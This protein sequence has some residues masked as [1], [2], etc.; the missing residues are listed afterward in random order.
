[1]ARAGNA[2]AQTQASPRISV[3]GTT[4]ANTW[5]AGG[6]LQH[7]RFRPLD[8]PRFGYAYTIP[9]VFAQDDLA[10]ARWLTLSASARIDRHS[11]RSAPSSA[12]DSPSLL[13]PAAQWTARVSGGGGHFAPSPFTEETGATGL[14]ILA[15]MQG[16]RPEDRIEHL[17]RRHV[18]KGAVRVD[19]DGVSLEHRGRAGVPEVG[20]WTICG[21]DRQRRNP[22]PHDRRGVHRALSHEEISTSS[23]RTCTCDRRRSARRGS[24]GA[25]SR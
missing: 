14:S 23:P 13:R 12:H 16:V 11:A 5:V 8:V 9:G 21:T 24:A 2:S 4:G 7:E 18:E 10:L 1:L 20:R 15:P 6:A 25:T 19:H 22:D 3:T 17:D